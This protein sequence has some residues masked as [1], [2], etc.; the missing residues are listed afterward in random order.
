MPDADDF[1]VEFFRTLMGGG[2]SKAQGK[3]RPEQAPAK[4]GAAAKG[5]KAP[6]GKCG[7]GPAKGKKKPARGRRLP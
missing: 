6:A 2:E 4:R 3:P 5:P 7:M 1:D